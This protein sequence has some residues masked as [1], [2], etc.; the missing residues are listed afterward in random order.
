MTS[1]EGVATDT[2]RVYVDDPDSIQVSVSDGTRITTIT[3]TNVVSQPPVANAGPDQIVECTGDHQ[4]IVHLDGSASTDPNGDIT[5]YQWY[6]NFGAADQVLLG[7]GETLD[8]SLALG[9]HAVTLK[10]TDATEKT[11]TDE[12]T[13]Q[14]VDTQPPT[15]GLSVNPSTIW[16]PN[17]KLVNVHATVRVDDC[18]PVTV[19]LVSVTSNEPDNGTGDGDTENDVQGADVG[20]NDSDFKV[21]AERSGGGSGR[22]YTVVYKVVDSV[23]LETTATAR[24]KV[25]HDQGGN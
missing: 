7:T 4:A 1:A 12:A 8:T 14:V 11:S 20:T 3:V 23:G 24:I 2:L 5:L 6:E 17:H 21:R 13:I 16:P 25:P 15:V 10:I 22:V 18:G 19:S 9:T